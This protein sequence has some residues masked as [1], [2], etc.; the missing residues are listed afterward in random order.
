MHSLVN[1]TLILSYMQ[2]KSGNV[3]IC[4]KKKDDKEWPFLTGRE[5]KLKDARE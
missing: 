1:V 2:I 3:T 5:K 4:L